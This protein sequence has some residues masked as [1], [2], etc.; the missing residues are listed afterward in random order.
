MIPVLRK[1]SELPFI[2]PPQEL[3]TQ[4]YKTTVLNYISAVMVDRTRTLT[5]CGFSNIIIESEIPSII[6]DPGDF[7]GVVD[8]AAQAIIKRSAEENKPIAIMYSGGMDSTCVTSAL[9]K[10]GASI[11]IVG[12]QAS[13]EENP[14]FYAEVLINNSSV[15]LEIGNPLLY[16]LDHSDEHLFITGEC[17]AH[18][19][20]T[21]NWTKY[22]GREIENVDAIE[23]DHLAAD[24]FRNPTP[25][26]NIPDD[27]KQLLLKVLDKA[28]R[29][30]HTNYDAQWWAIYAL[31]WQFVAYRTQLWIGKCCPNLINFFM[32]DEFQHWALSNDVRVKCPNYEW[33]NYKMPIR[34][35]IYSYFPNNAASYDLPKRASM[36]KTYSQL[37][38]R[39]RFV[40]DC[41]TRVG[42][43]RMTDSKRC[44]SILTQ[45]RC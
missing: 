26:F 29:T 10:N 14:V 24:I 36:D 38:L 13:I 11:K 43:M 2:V 1:F 18:L 21:I 31:K 20:G 25:Y 6:T 42:F 19:M 15:S 12:S 27:T 23:A 40:L 41:P 9:L 16:L 7:S 8:R 44:R 3:Y 28:P 33:R 32:N 30:F 35:Y 17:G 45:T 4:Q 5:D 22:G 39:G 37:S 34:D